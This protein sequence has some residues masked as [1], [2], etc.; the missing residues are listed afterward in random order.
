[1]PLQA[2]KDDRVLRLPEV[3][4]LTGLSKSGV[5]QAIQ[6]NHFPKPLKLGKR[7]SGWLQSEVSGWISSIAAAREVTHA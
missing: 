3:V 5:Y 7:A 2:I 1:M 6:D 4:S